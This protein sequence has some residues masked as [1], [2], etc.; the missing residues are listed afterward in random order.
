[1]DILDSHTHIHT[2]AEDYAACSALFPLTSCAMGACWPPLVGHGA[3]PT[4][5]S[6]RAYKSE[7]PDCQQTQPATVCLLHTDSHTLHSHVHAHTHIHTRTHTHTL[8][9]HTFTHTHTHSH[10][11]FT[12]THTHH[13]D[14]HIAFTHIHTHSPF[15]HAQ[16]HT[17]THVHMHPH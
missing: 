9:I 1:M 14:I 17:R 10:S 11:L 13:S 12:H 5:L 3:Q 8:L 7:Q 16:M 2:R 15:T 4:A 6:S